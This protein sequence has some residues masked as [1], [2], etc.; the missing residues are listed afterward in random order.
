MTSP[1]ISLRV[2]HAVL[3]LLAALGL[4]GCFARPAAAAE[5][6]VKTAANQFG[7]GRQDYRYTVNPG[8]T[9]EDSI[10]VE[11]PGTTPLHLTVYGADAFTTAAGRLDLRAEDAAAKGVG[12]WAHPAQA[13]VTVPA[14]GSVE[15][16]FSVTLP[17]EAAPGDY[18]GGIVTAD[19]DQRLPIQVRLRVGGALKPSLAV[20]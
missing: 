5:W 9:V 7:D 1:P 8:A 18:V 3:L 20:E 14:R 6:T 15:V 19:A 4:V 2:R 12:A 10:V 17:K 11:N 13:D 16:P